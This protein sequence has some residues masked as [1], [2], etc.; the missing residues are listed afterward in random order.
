MIIIEKKLAP[1]PSEVSFPA[2]VTFK[3]TLSDDEGPADHTLTFTLGKDNEL[4]WEPLDSDP[5]KES[6]EQVRIPTNAR[7]F[8]FTKK[9]FAPADIDLAFFRVGL[10][11][12]GTSGSACRVIVLS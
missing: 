1:E 4:S 3:V 2:K 11:A 5:V 10:K 8:E 6:E 9:I 7:P 12:P